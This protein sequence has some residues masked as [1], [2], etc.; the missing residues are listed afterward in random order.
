[1]AAADHAS[2][3]APRTAVAL[4]MAATGAAAAVG[5]L[6]VERRAPW[7]GFG[8]GSP[9]AVALELAA[10]LALIACAVA[11]ALRGTRGSAGW[12][13]AAVPWFAVEWDSP[14]AGSPVLFTTGLV[15]VAAAGPLAVHAALAHPAAGSPSPRT[16]IRR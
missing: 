13:V 6:V 11:S 10:G 12:L 3:R 16:W 7:F 14:A 4:A 5:C 9:A 2:S 1:M 8:E 15:A